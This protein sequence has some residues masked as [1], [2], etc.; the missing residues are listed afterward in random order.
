MGLLGSNINSAIVNDF[1]TSTTEHRNDH[2]TFPSVK[3]MSSGASLKL[4]LS[5]SQDLTQK[6]VQCSTGSATLYWLICRA[7]SIPWYLA[8]YISDMTKG[9][10]IKFIMIVH[11]YACMDRNVDC[12][13]TTIMDILNVILTTVHSMFYLCWIE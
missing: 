4:F 13:L 10:L 7:E 11:I 6:H 12:I 9:C 5:R 3:P 1:K 8:W 2:N